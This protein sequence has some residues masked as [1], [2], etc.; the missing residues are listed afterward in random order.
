MSTNRTRLGAAANCLVAAWALASPSDLERAA[1]NELIADAASRT[2]YSGAPKHAGMVLTDDSGNFSLRVGGLLQFRYVADFRSGSTPGTTPVPASGGVLN[3]ND[4]VTLGFTM[5]RTQ[6][7]FSGAAG[8]PELTPVL[9]GR[10]AT[11]GNGTFMLDDAFIRYAFNEQW[12]VKFGQFKLPLLTEFTIGDANQQSI[13]RSFMTDVYRQARSQAVQVG[14]TGN[15]LRVLGAISDGWRSANSDYNGAGEADYALTLRTDVKFAGEWAQATRFSSWQGS[16]FAAFLGGAVHWQQSGQTGNGTDAI[17]NVNQSNYLLWTVDAQVK[18]DGWNL[19]AAFVGSHADLRG[20][21]ALPQSTDNSYGWEVA[22]GWFA[23][24]Q[25]ELYARYDA[26]FANQALGGVGPLSP[27]LWNWVNIGVSYYFLP[28]SSAVKLTADV[29]V[30]L[31]RGRNLQAI[32]FQGNAATGQFV[33]GSTVAAPDPLAGV[34]GSPDAGEVAL[35]AQF[36]LAF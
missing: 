29:V 20:F 30:G 15:D 5:A 35:R 2:S 11:P 17:P 33:P 28:E 18:G 9:N 7:V 22:G 27:R 6:L 1:S 31:N 19:F 21:G 4:D 10:P 25:L 26:V 14:W 24:A 34:L 3:S 23:S 12:D 8:A 36:Q 32:N 16:K 13:D